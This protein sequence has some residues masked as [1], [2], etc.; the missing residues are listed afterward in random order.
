MFSEGEVYPCCW[1]GFYPKTYGAGQYHESV[2]SQLIPLIAKNNALEHSLEECISWFRQVEESW[3]IP[4]FE[5][6]RLVVCDNVCG[7][8]R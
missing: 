1:T 7:Q 3:N 6:G 2:N 5:Q 4:T 8:N